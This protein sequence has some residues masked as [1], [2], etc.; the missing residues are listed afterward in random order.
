[1]NKYIKLVYKL[2][3]RLTKPFNKT[4]SRLINKYLNVCNKNKPKILIYTDS[5]GLDCS[6]PFLMHNYLNTYIY[7]LNKI[8]RVD[9]FVAKE[10]YTTWLDF[11]DHLE[12]SKIK[13]DYYIVHIGIVDYAIRNESSLK[14]LI[15]TKSKL[16]EKYEIK[17]YGKYFEGKYLGEDTYS[18]ASE[19]YID[20]IIKM[21]NQKLD[22]KII[23]LNCNV[24]DDEFLGTYW[25]KRPDNLNKQLQI[26]DYFLANFDVFLINLRDLVG[27]NQELYTVDN[28]HYSKIGHEL[29]S[30][31]IIN[32]IRE[33]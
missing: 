4:Y 25:R 24:I 33:E 9:Y 27:N 16:V 20:K 18:F 32:F 8:F 17:K 28:V 21:L 29:I 31:N 12:N 11:L 5:R 13:Y 10:K 26:E 15:S 30:R 6:S 3:L 1:M 7:K 14:D 23:Y 22:K 19:K 2:K